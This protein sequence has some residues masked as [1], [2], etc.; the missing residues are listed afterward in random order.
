M[1][2]FACVKSPAPPP[3]LLRAQEMRLVDV[4]RCDVEYVEHLCQK[5][6]KLLGGLMERDLM[7]VPPGR[8]YIFSSRRSHLPSEVLMSIN[9][10]IR[11]DA[12]LLVNYW[13]RGHISFPSHFVWPKKQHPLMDSFSPLH[14]NFWVSKL[15]AIG[16]W[17]TI[18]SRCMLA[19]AIL[20]LND[21]MDL[22][23]LIYASKHRCSRVIC[24]P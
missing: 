19:N 17:K 6:R 14:S 23:L 7:R 11:P 5:H 18:D 21:E 3:Q 4:S 2:S 10:L 13:Y 9:C 12:Y 15:L 24:K 20:D 1:Y 16:T 8:L 22:A